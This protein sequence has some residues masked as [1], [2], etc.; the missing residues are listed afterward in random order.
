MWPDA[1]I[2]LGITL[3]I[4]VLAQRWTGLDTPDSSFYTSLALFGDQVTD[5]A[6]F[7]SYYWT[8]LGQ[9]APTMALTTLL[10]PWIGFAAYRM[11]LLFVIVASAYVTLRRFTGRTTAAVLTALITMSTVVLSYLGNPYLTGSILAG[12]SLLIALAFSDRRTT[13]AAAGATIGWLVMVLPPGA[14]LAT[15]I[16]F[17]LR[18]QRWRTLG[19][20]QALAH[21]GIAAV[22]AIVA[23]GVF[24]GLGRVIFPRM[25]WFATYAAALSVKGSDF[26]SKTPVWVDDISMLVP[27]GIAVVTVVAWLMHR[28]NK[29]VQVAATISVTSIVT[30]AVISTA[31]MGGIALEAPMYQAM[32]WPPALFALALT[33]VAVAGREP[34]TRTTTAVAG[35]AIVAVF[36]AGHWAGALA[37]NTGRVLIVVFIAAALAGL[38]VSK[39]LG[40]Q[41]GAITG[42]AILLAGAQLLQNSRGPLGLYYLSPYNWAFNA[43]PISDKLHTSVNTQEWLL[44]KT[45]KDDR[46]LNWVGGNWV[47]GDRELYV[48]AGMQLWGENRVTLEPTI[49]D[50]DLPR[51]NDLKPSVIAMYSPTTKQVLA[52]WQSIPQDNH[53]TAPECYDFTWPVDPGVGHACLTRLDWS[54]S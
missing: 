11:L 39:N 50:I 25:D 23:F 3:A 48:V 32:L 33:V 49:T 42:V 19:T 17:V 28:N 44:S 14:L 9:I 24:L 22:A 31:L 52:F 45:T 4:G 1:A 43:N 2:V 47:Q 38:G 29:T 46:I 34:W 12:T 53:A 37:L 35:L 8:R 54:A 36:L 18:L 21:F 13:T 30:L 26:A 41:I 51:L 27:A 16:W 40:L 6:V 7:T 10:G 20:R 15:A 5:R